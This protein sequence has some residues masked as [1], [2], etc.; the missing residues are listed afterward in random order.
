[1]TGS[2]IPSPKQILS[3][4]RAISAIGHWCLTTTRHVAAAK[5]VK[6]LLFRHVPEILDPPDDNEKN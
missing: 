5:E 3:Y 6:A 2:S 4:M 1:M